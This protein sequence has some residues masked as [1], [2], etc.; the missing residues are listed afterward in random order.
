MRYAGRLCRTS[1][2]MSAYLRWMQ[3]RVRGLV[4]SPTWRQP[5]QAL[6][7]HLLHRRQL[8]AREARTIIRGAIPG[9]EGSGSI[10]RRSVAGSN[11]RAAA[12]ARRSVS[13]GARPEL[14]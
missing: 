2:E 6:A 7:T 14:R 9:T 13:G 4:A 8:G 11:R 1:E 5:I 10:R 12:S 3:L